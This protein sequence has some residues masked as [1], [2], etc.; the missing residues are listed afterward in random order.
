MRATV[1]GTLFFNDLQCFQALVKPRS[2]VFPLIHGVPSLQRAWDNVAIG[3]SVHAKP[4]RQLAVI[5]LTQARAEASPA[6]TVGM[7][8]V[9]EKCYPPHR[10]KRTVERTASRHTQEL[11]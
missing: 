3:T 4:Q 2:Y 8:D 5:R 7:T 10:R 11:R 9:T 6:V 1:Q